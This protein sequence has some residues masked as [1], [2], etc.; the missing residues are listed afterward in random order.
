MILSQALARSEAQA[1]CL[2][3][4]CASTVDW[5]TGRGRPPLFCGRQHLDTYNRARSQLLEDLAVISGQLKMVAAGTQQAR[6]LRSAA[7]RVRW[8]LARYPALPRK[9]PSAKKTTAA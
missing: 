4:M 6:S 1:A 9:T 8:H 5:P 3:P 2:L 7:A